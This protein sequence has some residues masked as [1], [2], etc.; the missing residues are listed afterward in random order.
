MAKYGPSGTGFINS[1]VSVWEGGNGHSGPSQLPSV[2]AA[3]LAIANGPLT[4]VDQAKIA[5]AATT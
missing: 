5:T 4:H 3:A 1:A 2:F